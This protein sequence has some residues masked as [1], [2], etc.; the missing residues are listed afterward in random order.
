MWR[1]FLSWD[2]VRGSLDVSGGCM[3]FLRIFGKKKE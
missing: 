3:N 1:I 2:L